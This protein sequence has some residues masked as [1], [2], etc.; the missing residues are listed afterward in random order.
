M[1]T[2]SFSNIDRVVFTSDLLKVDDRL[3][4]K[5]PNPQAINVD[6]TYELFSSFIVS[7]TG[8]PASKYIA[9]EH[10]RVSWYHRM[11]EKFSSAGWAR[12]YNAEYTGGVSDEIVHALA[13]SLVI[14]FEMPGSMIKALDQAGIPYI[15][16]SIHPIR[17]ARDYFF[18]CRSNNLELAQKIAELAVDPAYIEG[19]VRISKA[20]SSRV[21]RNRKIV[22]GSA[23]FLGQIEIDSSLIDNGLIADARTTEYALLSLTADYGKVYYKY[24]PHRKERGEI[25]AIL[26]KIPSCEVMEVNIYDLLWAPEVFCFAS[27]S[28]GS[29]HEARA[30]GRATKRIISSTEDPFC[31]DEYVHGPTYLPVP[32]SIFTEGF[33]RRLLLGDD[34]PLETPDYVDGAFRFSV[35]QKWGR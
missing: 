7:I 9:D 23:V 35:N 22:P 30:F 17:F 14:G 29:L 28:S 19:F 34:S 13:N 21:Y 32:G 8:L 3:A 18:G 6:W 11:G 20:R 4:N 12:H 26:K 15:D 5:A 24:H 27:L 1:N 16:L 10:T 2:F 31:H 25:E 33:W